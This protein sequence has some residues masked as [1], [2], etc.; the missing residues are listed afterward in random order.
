MANTWRIYGR[1]HSPTLFSL[2][3]FGIGGRRTN[4]FFNLSPSASSF[5]S[6]AP[7]RFT[8]RA[9]TVA[10]IRAKRNSLFTQH[11]TSVGQ[12]LKHSFIHS[13]TRLKIFQWKILI[14]RVRAAVRQGK[15]EQQRFNPKNIPKIRNDRN[16]AAFTD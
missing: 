9:S 15:S 13:D 4:N 10:I 8:L 5:S 2:R 7:E 11:T 16:A 6:V 1:K 3:C 12:F 14:G